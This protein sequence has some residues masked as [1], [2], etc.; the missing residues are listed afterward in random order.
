MVSFSEAN[1][2][3]NP[4]SKR[5]KSSH[6]GSHH[7]QSSI[8]QPPAGPQLQSKTSK[9]KPQQKQK[10]ASRRTRTLKSQPPRQNRPI[11]QYSH[12]QLET[13]Q[14]NRLRAKS[15][16]R[17][18][19]S[20]I[21][22]ISSA[23]A[24]TSGTTTPV[25][26]ER[27]TKLSTTKSLLD[28]IWARN[29]NQHRS[30]PWWKS[31][32]MLRKAITHLVA[33]DEAEHSLKLLQG[34]V[35][36]IDAKQVRQRFEQETQI[37]REREVWHGWMREVLVP[38]AY[39]GFTALV[40]DTQFAALGVVLVGILADVMGVVG[41]PTPTPMEDDQKARAQHRG[42]IRGVLDG[43]Q[44]TTKAQPLSKTLMAR[45]LRV[46][47]SQSG[48]IVER[49]YDSDDLG[50][51]IERTNLNRNRN[52][53]GDSAGV[54]TT[55]L[56][57]ESKSQRSDSITGDAGST[58]TTAAVGLD[59]SIATVDNAANV[60]GPSVPISD[61][62]AHR[63]NANARKAVNPRDELSI[64]TP[65]AS[66]RNHLTSM[67]AEA[68]RVQKQNPDTTSKRGESTRG[69]ELRAIESQHQSSNSNDSGTKSQSKPK[70]KVKVKK[71]T[72]ANTTTATNTTTT[73]GIAAA[74]ASPAATVAVA[75]AAAPAKTKKMSAPTATT[76]TAPVTATSTKKAKEKGKDKKEMKM[77]KKK[78]A[79]DDMFSGF[80]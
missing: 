79:I 17:S 47:G 36:S 76:A 6:Q 9:S 34:S 46:T 26:A 67:E 64:G 59:D 51:V 61:T 21:K 71:S 43:A 23:S 48:K 63:T 66:P 55:P 62:S 13:S 30:Q 11:T 8:I 10:L 39:V 4:P 37:R 14:T 31:L 12:G 19:L 45:S 65:S 38:R 68:D 35:A 22:K 58:V 3:D 44:T 80:I 29:K 33:M 40:A 60:V 74:V 73:S 28:Q 75:A 27:S 53:D 78:N 70:A 2:P 7:H 49:M 57:L 52:G 54:D 25:S 50:E 18:S 77:K 42:G 16:P 32:G 5:R 24:S 41:A 72:T 20:S 56:G 15:F 69:Q 1:A